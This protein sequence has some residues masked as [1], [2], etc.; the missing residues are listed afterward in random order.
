M[1]QVADAP[2]IAR[3]GRLSFHHFDP[4]AQALAK[5]ERSHAQDIEDVREMTRRGL[6]DPAHALRY[7]ES[8]EPTLYRYPAI[9]PASFRRAVEEIFGAGGTGEAAEAG[10]PLP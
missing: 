8:I 2:F 7:F 9:D 6:I 4:Y 10:E 1:R 3:E 5:V